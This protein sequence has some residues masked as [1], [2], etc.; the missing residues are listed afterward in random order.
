MTDERMHAGIVAAVLSNELFEDEANLIRFEGENSIQKCAYAGS[1]EDNTVNAVFTLPSHSH[2]VFLTVSDGDPREI[3]RTLAHLDE[4]DSRNC[5]HTG[6]VVRFSTEY[7]ENYQKI[8]VVL[9]HIDVS[10]ALCGL[11]EELAFEEKVYTPMLVL[12]LSM[13]EYLVWKD[14]GFGALMKQF[15][16]KG[17]DLVSIAA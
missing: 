13:E 17:R 11:A 7:M 12:F 5:I 16:E 6:D 2:K 9:L 1:Q 15:E 14:Y 10:P 4:V 3:A 8:G